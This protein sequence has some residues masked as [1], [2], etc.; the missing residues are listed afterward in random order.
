MIW[1]LMILVI[2]AVGYIWPVTIILRRMGYS[3]WWALL[4]VVSPLNM[5]GLWV[6]ARARWPRVEEKL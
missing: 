6:L 4:T 1:K 2:F 5:I 3:P